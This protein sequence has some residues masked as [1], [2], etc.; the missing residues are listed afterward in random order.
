MTGM[1]EGHPDDWLELVA[2]SSRISALESSL[3]VLEV[4]NARLTA[5][6]EEW[7]DAAIGAESHALEEGERRVAA[8]ARL[9]RIRELAQKWRDQEERDWMDVNTQACGRAILAVMD[10]SAVLDGS[11]SPTEP[12]HAWYGQRC[13]VPNC[14]ED[15]CNGARTGSTSPKP[16]KMPPDFKVEFEDDD[17]AGSTSPQTDQKSD[18]RE[19]A[20]EATAEGSK[21]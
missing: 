21:E 18:I 6:A 7:K 14:I 20:A 19:D 16:R 12:H 11:T 8:E 13:N 4:E 15:F 3:S 2:A 1:Y 10:L 9:T 5:E 17:P